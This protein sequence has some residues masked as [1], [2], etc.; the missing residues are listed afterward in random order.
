M[1]TAAVIFLL[2]VVAAIVWWFRWM[3]RSMRS[4]TTAS[5]DHCLKCGVDGLHFDRYCPRCGT[6]TPPGPQDDAF[7]RNR[8]K[9]IDI[10]LEDPR[11]I[12]KPNFREKVVKAYETDY[13]DTARA[14][15]ELLKHR[16]IDADIVEGPPLGVDRPIVAYHVAVYESDLRPARALLTEVGITRFK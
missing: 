12:R 10:M 13:W 2:A 6:G 8:K 4:M 1:K 3:I 9:W 5:F 14:V 11:P 7:E 16:G 15:V